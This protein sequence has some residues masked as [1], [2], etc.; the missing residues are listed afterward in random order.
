MAISDV[1][2]EAVADILDY[3]ESDTAMQTRAGMTRPVNEPLEELILR[4][5]VMTYLRNSPLAP[6][7]AYDELLLIIRDQMAGR[8]TEAEALT[9]IAPVIRQAAGTFAMP[10]P[11]GWDP[12]CRVSWP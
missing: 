1:L 9:R 6:P 4:M 12:L 10:I 11:S 3:Q 5:L 8:I 2:V 7:S